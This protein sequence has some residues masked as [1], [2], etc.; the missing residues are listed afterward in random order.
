MTWWGALGLA[1]SLYGAVVALEWVYSR[2]LPWPG[3]VPAAITVVLYVR[4]Q[5]NILERAVSDL[6]EVWEDAAWQRW[7]MEILIVDGGS[8]DQTLAIAKRLERRFP[9]IIVT[10]SRLD[11][12]QVLDMCRH[13]VII[14]IDLTHMNPYVPLATLK[15]L[16]RHSEPVMIRSIG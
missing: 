10:P 5:E 7:D 8:S 14:W 13:D 1:L 3:L 16:L 9:F 4:D 12:G 6:S 15:S 2:I 11:K